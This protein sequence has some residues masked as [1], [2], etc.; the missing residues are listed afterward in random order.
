MELSWDNIDQVD[1]P[2][3]TQQ[4]KPVE[5]KSTDSNLTWESLEPK[6]PKKRSI[7]DDVISFGKGAIGAPAG[8]IKDTY[9]AFQ[10][11]FGEPPET[12][13][14][15]YNEF[16]QG[17]LTEEAYNQK[18]TDYANKYDKNLID[19]V[20]T[21]INIKTMFKAAGAVP[22]PV[23]DTV[24]AG[25]SAY[26][27]AKGEDPGDVG[28]DVGK[29][30]TYRTLFK[31]GGKTIGKIQE[32]RTGIRI[33][34]VT[35]KKEFM[36]KIDPRKVNINDIMLKARRVEPVTNKEKALSLA[37]EQYRKAHGLKALRKPFKLWVPDATVVPVTPVALLED[38]TRSVRNKITALEKRVNLAAKTP[39]EISSK[40]ASTTKV[41]S[42]TAKGLATTIFNS[43]EA[44]IARQLE[45]PNHFKSMI[46]SYDKESLKRATGTQ[47]VT[48]RLQNAKV[49]IERNT[50]MGPSL[51]TL[52]D[53]TKDLPQLMYEGG[54]VGPVNKYV[55]LPTIDSFFRKVDMSDSL[56]LGSTT[57]IQEL[58]PKNYLTQVETYGN[59][60]ELKISW[61]QKIAALAH[62]ENIENRIILAKSG[63]NETVLSQMS[64]NLTDNDIKILNTI[65]G[66][67]NKTTPGI[68]QPAYR[69]IHGDHIN[70]PVSPV[71]DLNR[72]Q[73]QKYLASIPKNPKLSGYGFPRMYENNQ[74]QPV[75][76]NR[77]TQLLE[78]INSTHVNPRQQTG[79]LEQRKKAQGISLKLDLDLFEGIK[80]HNDLVARFGS[81]GKTLSEVGGILNKVENIHKKEFG[82]ANVT[83]MRN[84]I[85]DLLIGAPATPGTFSKMI[86]AQR[87]ATYTATL[88]Q[89]PTK[90]ALM[91]TASVGPAIEIVGLNNY[92]DAVEDFLSNPK[93][94]MEDVNK[95]SPLMRTRFA[96]YTQADIEN[97]TKLAKNTNIAKLTKGAKA[98]NKFMSIP[99]GT[100]DK[101][102]AYPTWLAGRAKWLKI[103]P[104]DTQG[105]NKMG[106][107]AAMTTQPMTQ[108]A[109]RPEITRRD[110]MGKNMMLYNSGRLQHGNLITK[111]WAN[112]K[113][114]NIGRGEFVKKMYY[115]LFLPALT[116]GLA[117]QS[118]TAPE[119]RPK[120][121]Q[122][123]GAFYAKSVVNILPGVTSFIG[124][125]EYNKGQM[126]LPA[127][128]N[129]S[130]A[131]KYILK[132]MNSK[133][134]IEQLA[135]GIQAALAVPGLNAQQVKN[136]AA[137]AKSAIEQ[138]P[139]YKRMIMS[140]YQAGN[141]TL[142]QEIRS[143][144]RA[145][146]KSF[147][148]G[149]P[150]KKDFLRDEIDEMLR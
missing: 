56:T 98:Y 17:N 111:A 117:V 27:I 149:I 65:R 48:R 81:M 104:G 140:E 7:W 131:G 126:T 30:L 35:G 73:Y 16:H 64:K 108:E 97:A 103:H 68:I 58:A 124:A 132:T 66:H 115:Y 85:S 84:W 107:I 92:Q 44:Q 21:A 101:M 94:M 135:N 110:P 137:F 147:E 18:V 14:E 50:L 41:K 13:T 59:Q 141:Q 105:A 145:L 88:T 70:L 40:L 10:D 8:M 37:L 15:I 134:N 31:V 100:M 26:R 22:R 19:V 96:H 93:Q 67:L 90:V 4:I 29:I 113:N 42:D 83:T 142:E 118:Y 121:P 75:L 138:D 91:Q 51:G 25:S 87:M 5:E 128:G 146:E 24:L 43:P 130:L 9:Q 11:S 23:W 95:V 34:P 54:E 45:K 28:R 144:T 69:D 119:R 57:P 86:D 80:K 99:T 139:Q 32:G 136:A 72:E 133:S 2:K 143:M 127:L 55:V 1:Q 62:A 120:T 53:G 106:D 89:T 79:F 109:F 78:E 116:T 82:D 3:Q 129:I 33:N 114:K 39:E 71:G 47:E 74:G 52:M 49:F 112:Y 60:G 150:T 61:H 77:M 20:Q 102:V 76:Q 63:I 12:L 36:V 122:E 125:M 6:V 38:R 148:K 46:K 123:A